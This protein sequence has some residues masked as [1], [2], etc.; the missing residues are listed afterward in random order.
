MRPTVVKCCVLTNFRPAFIT[1][2]A[3][4][5]KAGSFPPAKSRCFSPA[6]YGYEIGP[7]CST[8]RTVRERVAVPILCL[9]CCSFGTVDR[10]TIWSIQPRDRAC[11]SNACIARYVSRQR[12]YLAL[13]LGCRLSVFR[14]EI[15]DPL[16]C[17]SRSEE[18]V[19][20]TIR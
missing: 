20:A 8:E 9:R 5:F 10:N 17:D 15:T 6:Q 19:S 14:A 1:A 4:I 11:R 3:T 13:W 12:V 16:K 2:G 18:Q 7:G